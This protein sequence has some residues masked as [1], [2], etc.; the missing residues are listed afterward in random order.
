MARINNGSML[1]GTVLAGNPVIVS[2]SAGTFPEKSSF[3]QIV[4]DVIGDGKELQFKTEVSAS[5]ETVEFDISSALRS[6]LWGGAAEP[7]EL[8][9]SAT[10]YNRSASFGIRVHDEYLMDGEIWKTDAVVNG[11]TN[12]LAIGGGHW[13]TD[14]TAVT[15]DQTA[16]LS[17]TRFTDKPSSGEVVCQGTPYFYSDFYSGRQRT[18]RTTYNTLG[19]ATRDGR[20]LYITEL[21]SPLN[22]MQCI[23][24]RNHYGV[25]ETVCCH[26]KPLEAVSTL[27][28][29]YVRQS[30]PSYRPGQKGCGITAGP[31]PYVR[32][33]SGPLDDDWSRWWNTEVCAATEFWLWHRSAWWPCT[34]EFEE[35]HDV[36]DR[37]KQELPSVD[38]TLTL[39]YKGGF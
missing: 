22:G 13:E 7:Q 35:K 23:A 18:R 9:S 11:N 17:S 38:F 28:T 24:F 39:L 16:W 14:L 3:R 33:S 37:S 8:V 34:V 25:L 15:M 2:V 12:N 20:N 21:P 27:R 10:A 32:L 5:G 1:G 6:L 26:G 4:L 29:N 30:A 31:T 19:A 36:Y